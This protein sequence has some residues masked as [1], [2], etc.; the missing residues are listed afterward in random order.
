MQT[1][2]KENGRS[3]LLGQLVMTVTVAVLCLSVLFAWLLLRDPSLAWFASN[4]RTESSGM[5][6]GA[7]N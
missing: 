2:G 6:I 3:R 7:K 1:S 4:K 5:Q